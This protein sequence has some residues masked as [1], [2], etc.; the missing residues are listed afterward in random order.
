MASATSNETAVS[1]SDYQAVSGTV[2]FPPGIPSMTIAMPVFGDG[3]FEPNE[4]FQVTLSSPTN[5]SLADP[6]GIGTILDDASRQT[7]GDF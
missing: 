5:A 3:A 4:T 1:G 6:Y 2:V 7:W